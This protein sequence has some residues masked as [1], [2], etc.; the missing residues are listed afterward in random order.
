[1]VIVFVDLVVAHR[2][3][4]K[5]VPVTKCDWFGLDNSSGNVLCLYSIT[6]CTPTRD[7]VNEKFSFR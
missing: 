5:I 7:I 1:M 4:G 6:T 2:Q 3:E